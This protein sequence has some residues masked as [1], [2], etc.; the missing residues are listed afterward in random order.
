MSIDASFL[1]IYHDT[2]KKAVMTSDMSDKFEAVCNKYDELKDKIDAR[3][4]ENGSI[5]SDAERL[6]D[7]ETG[8]LRGEAE[9][10]IGNDRALRDML[11]DFG[12]LLLNKRS[13]AEFG[14]RDTLISTIDPVLAIAEYSDME[15]KI[16]AELG[17][18]DG[19][20]VI[21]EIKKKVVEFEKELG[22]S[23]FGEEILRMRDLF[24]IKRLFSKK[25]EISV[26]D[27]DNLETQKLTL[28]NNDGELLKCEKTAQITH[29]GSLYIEL[30]ILE[31]I[32]VCVF[33]YYVFKQS[34]NCQSLVLVE[35]KALE[36]ILDGKRDKLETLN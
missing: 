5:C 36:K 29:N 28:T 2:L 34:D 26:S 18:D 25:G 3:L 35:D 17:L 16:I 23:F 24:R 11:T 30:E 4:E 9:S 13:F 6:F 20:K 10:I 7:K 8:A 1:K 15:K 22:I 12:E 14:W 19:Q 27:K 31:D 33:N 32:R 21:Y